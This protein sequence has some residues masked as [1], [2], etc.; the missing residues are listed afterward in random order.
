MDLEA[1]PDPRV[2]HTPRATNLSAIVAV[3]AHMHDCGNRDEILALL[4]EALPE[5]GPFTV[6][7]VSALTGERHDDDVWRHRVLL[8]DS[9]S[10]STR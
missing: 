3:T 7:P 8:D 6:E 4:V 5:L 2:D 1:A 10:S 9:W